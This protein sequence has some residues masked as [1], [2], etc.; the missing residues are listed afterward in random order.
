MCYTFGLHL[1]S[2]L[3]CL[4]SLLT[5]LDGYSQTDFCIY[6]IHTR[7]SNNF[8]CFM[9]PTCHNDF[10]PFFYY[11]YCLGYI[12]SLKCLN[13]HPVLLFEYIYLQTTSRIRKRFDL[14]S[15]KEFVHAILNLVFFY[16]VPV[17]S[18]SSLRLDESFLSMF[19]ASV[20]SS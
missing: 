1:H 10:D 9:Y 3:C 19:P 6:C 5:Y 7:V 4:D 2:A 13:K 17:V 14:V 18:S 12:L 15:F 8:L 20:L 11:F 16:K